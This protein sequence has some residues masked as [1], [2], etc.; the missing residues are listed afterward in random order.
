M[1]KRK[2]EYLTYMVNSKEAKEELKILLNNGWEPISIAA[3]NA[4]PANRGTGFYLFYLLRK[5]IE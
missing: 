2:Y 5:P 1:N 3:S 4:G